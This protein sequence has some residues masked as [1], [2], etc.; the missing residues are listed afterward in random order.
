L[1]R[2]HHATGCS[3][4]LTHAHTHTRRLK[5][6]RASP[7]AVADASVVFTHQSYLFYDAEFLSRHE[8]LDAQR[9]VARECALEKALCVKAVETLITTHIFLSHNYTFDMEAPLPAGGDGG[10]GDGTRGA[11]AA[12]K[13]VKK[14]KKQ[15]ARG[16]AGGE[17]AVDTSLDLPQVEV[18]ALYARHR[19][20]I[21]AYLK[22]GGSAE[23]GGLGASDS[24]KCSGDQLLERV[25]LALTGPRSM[26]K[27]WRDDKDGCAR[28]WDSLD[29]P[30]CNGRLCPDTERKTFA[31]TVLKASAVAQAA[32]AGAGRGRYEEWLRITTTAAVETELNLQLGT[33][34]LKSNQTELLAAEFRQ[35]PDFSSVFGAKD[36][37]QVRR[38]SAGSPAKEP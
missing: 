37:L 38:T 25:I 9:R 19:N 22:G 36:R 16:K 30:G 6:L 32:A 24:V 11:D 14:D 13:K 21:L 23:A 10:G 15:A 2:D 26:G 4:T 34:T 33:F 7:P 29:Y 1:L 18:F 31:D 8:A 28:R 17:R 12:G 27:S 35:L 20:G 3:V 5:L